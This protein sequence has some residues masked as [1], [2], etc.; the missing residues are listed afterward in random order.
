MGSCDCP[1]FHSNG[2]CKHIGG[3]ARKIAEEYDIL[4]DL[5]LQNS[6]LSPS[7]TFIDN[8]TTNQEDFANRYM[9]NPKLLTHLPENLDA[10]MIE[11]F[12]KHHPEYLVKKSAVSPPRTPSPLDI[13][14][15]LS[16]EPITRES[17][18]EGLRIKVEILRGISPEKNNLF[19]S[20]YQG[21]I[22]KNGNLSVGKKLFKSDIY[23]VK[24]QKFSP[25]LEDRNSGGYYWGNSASNTRMSFK[26]APEF[27][28]QLLT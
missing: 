14:T 26:S 25:F 10:S 20:L 17:K 12:L 2:R 5:T 18:E 22:Q 6:P 27:F 7:D 15:G 9:V 4:D 21:K 23:D 24:Y 19:L 13:F 3:F 28:I 11:L 16:D 1:S 8:I